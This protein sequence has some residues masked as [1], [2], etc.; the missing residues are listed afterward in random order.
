MRVYVASTFG[1]LR[2]LADSGSLAAPIDGHAV[3][4]ALRESYAEGDTEELEYVAL[5]AAALDSLRAIAASPDEPCRRVVVAVDVPEGAI[6]HTGEQRSAVTVTADMQLADVASVL[7]DDLA[8]TPLVAAAIGALAAAESG[9]E[10][11]A[12]T[13]SEIEGCELMWFATQ[14]I[15]DLLT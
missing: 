5:T 14:E 8:A 10:D 6:R 13:V 1:G 7:V 4:A 3:T 2:V 15:G 12:F 11:A 9:D